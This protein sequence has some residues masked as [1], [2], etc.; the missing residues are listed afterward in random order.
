MLNHHTGNNSVIFA[1][2]HE[3]RHSHYYRAIVTIR[4]R[5]KIGLTYMKVNKNGLTSRFSDVVLH[6]GLKISTY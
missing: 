4:W 3:S 6:P 5:K 1:S 2:S